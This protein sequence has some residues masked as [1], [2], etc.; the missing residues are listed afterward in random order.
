MLEDRQMNSQEDK[1]EHTPTIA[2]YL[3]ASRWKHALFTTY[4]LSLSYFESE[5]LRP[6]LQ[7]G[8]DDIWLICDAQGYRSSLLE[9]RSMRVGQEYRIVPVGLPSGVFHPKCIHLCSDEEQV[10]LIGS[11]NVTFGGHGRNA[12]VFEALVP[13]KHA[14]A[15]SDFS[16][17]LETLGTG[18]NIKIARR[19][20]IDDFAGRASEAAA[21]G[22]DASDTPVRLLHPIERSGIE[23]LGEAAARLGACSSV[24]VISPYHDPDGEAVHTLLNALDAEAGVV[25]VTS[26]G[27]SPFPFSDAERWTRTVLPQEPKIDGKRFVHAKWIECIFADETLLLT[28]SF[29]ATRKALT[30]TDNVELGVLRRVPKGED[31][32]EWA[33]CGTPQFEPAQRLPSGLGQSEIVYASFDRNDPRRLYGQLISLQDVSGKWL[34]RVV[35]ADGTSHAGDAAINDDGE[36]SVI[37]ETLEAF[38]E[39]PALQIVLQRDEREARGWIHNEMLLSVGARRRLTAGAMSRLMRREASDD[40]IQALLDYL[41]VS[42][43]KHLRVFDLPVSKSE[44]VEGSN[45]TDDPAARTVRINLQEL[46]PLAELPESVGAAAGFAESTDDH[47]ETALV[48]LRRMLLGHGVSRNMAMRNGLGSAIL[49]EDEEDDARRQTPEQIAY[50]LGLQDFEYA[51][52]AM[53]R[54]CAAHPDKLPGLLTIELEIGMWMRLH[55]LEDIDGAFEFMGSWIR[56]AAQT[57]TVPQDSV[58]ALSQH[59]VTATAIRTALLPDA[60]KSDQLVALHDDLEKFFGGPVDH[61][62]AL[63][64][65]IEDS[66][67]GF[68]AALAQAD[69]EIDLRAALESVLATRTRRQQLEDALRLRLARKAVPADWEVFQSKTGKQLH[70]AMHRPAWKK[71][72][73]KAIPNYEACSHCYAKYPLQELAV[74]RR[75]RIGRC[76]QC[77]KFSL[78]LLP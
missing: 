19:D 70:E 41:S 27:N 21:G 6:L 16:A 26:D 48:R 13:D 29:N 72:I 68:A 49:L 58:N 22:A 69:E 55:R 15:Y 74:L 59:F 45:T 5:I 51:I 57:V 30:T 66:H 73:K 4:A 54:D 75:E 17:F 28:G 31:V 2:E 34:Y 37:D 8:C 52:D 18:P 60:R 39:L 64:A 11:G 61:S 71:R 14:M 50:S 7:Q 53:I 25:A 67:Q 40:D 46:A 62:F 32:L 44:E 76:I 63:A 38:A 10:L 12:E 3:S 1:E 78:D 9:R 56:R 24:K 23:Q 42:A 36:F 33:S 47:F 20:W 35:Q 77:K 65:L 43:N